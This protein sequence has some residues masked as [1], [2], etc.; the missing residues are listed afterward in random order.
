MFKAISQ[1]LLGSKAFDIDLEIMPSLLAN[2]LYNSL[3]PSFLSKSA[4]KDK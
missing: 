2:K 1:K 3:M 4:T